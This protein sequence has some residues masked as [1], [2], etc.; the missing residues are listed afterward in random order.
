MPIF[1][2]SPEVD[3]APVSPLVSDD[4]RPTIA[5]WLRR[6]VEPGRVLELRALKVPT[7]SRGTYAPTYAGYYDTDHLDLMADMAETLT[8]QGAGGVYLTLN[9]VEPELLGRCAN[10]DPEIARHAVR[11]ADVVRRT[12]LLLDLDTRRYSRTTGKEL[13]AGLSATDEEKAGTLRVAEAIRRHLTVAGWPEPALVDSGNGYYL[14]YGID[15]PADDGGLVLR[16]L[17]AVKARFDGPAAAIDEAVT[18]PARLMKVP[19]TWARKG[20]PGEGRP[21]RRSRM[22]EGPDRLRAAPPALLEA[23]AAEAPAAGPEPGPRARPAGAGGAGAGSPAHPPAPAREGGAPPG[24]DDRLVRRARAFVLRKLPPSVAGKQ[25]HRALFRAAMVLLDDY[26]L[27]DDAALEVLRAYNARPDGDPEGERQ[28]RHKIAGARARI[29]QRGGPSLRRA[30]AR[31]EPGAA[32]RPAPAGGAPVDDPH[33]L[34]RL[35]RAARDTPQ[36]EPCVY[37]WRGEWWAWDGGAYRRVPEDEVRCELVRTIRSEFDR[38]GRTGRP[39]ARANGTRSGPR[40]RPVTQALVG[41]VLL[42]LRSEALL[43]HTVDQPDWLGAAPAPFPAYEVL[44][45]R[46]ALVHLPTRATA[47]P[48][49]AYFGSYTLG[50]DYDPNA[51]EPAGWLAFLRSLW[52]DDADC[53]GTLQEWFGYC[54]SSDTSQQRI[55]FL[56]GPTRSGKGTI[57]RILQHM[58]GPENCAGPTLAG[59][60]T[61]FGLAPLIGKPAAVVGDARLSSRTDQA[62]VTERLLSISG[63][64]TLTI[65]RKNRAPWTGRLGTRIVLISN[66]N[67]RLTDS[68][69]ALAGRFLVLPLTRSFAGCEDRGLEG[70]LLGELPGIL[71]WA[72]AGWERL[73]QRGHFSQPASGRILVEEL[74]ELSSRITT[75]VGDCCELGA[76]H[77]EPISRLYEAWRDWCAAQGEAHPDCLRAFARELRTAVPTLGSHATKVEGKS[78][79][80]Y[81]G[82]RLR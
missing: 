66:E 82:I 45:T 15:L 7:G 43:P 38:G 27:D 21:H 54:L 4:W 34:A 53:I 63:Q 67:P 19:G 78:A 69:L 47:P 79:K 61:Q 51:A 13:A 25:G 29:D 17:K 23:L 40:H 50:Y 33:R 58:I 71:N 20:D 49:P 68:S 59:M 1:D 46:N 22:L 72:V 26:G 28:L 52:G 76:G 39:A 14:I 48:T 11:D 73:R 8:G 65:D 74:R 55:L 16:A 75:F 60:G 30:G 44:P 31:G 32:P 9:P 3:G 57:G 36:G 2:G 37:Y 12:R 6:L 70:R 81:V 77:R 42:A 10:R 35:Y 18:N 41:N 80:V 5:G 24:G 64:D 62:V 56:V